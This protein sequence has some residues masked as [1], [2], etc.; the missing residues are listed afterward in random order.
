METMDA[1]YTR[2]SIRN[3]KNELVPKE[4]IAQLLEAAT[5]APSGSNS[6]PWRFVVIQDR[7]ALKNYSSRAKELWLQR[8]QGRPDPQDYKKLLAN[9]DFH[10]FYNAGTLVIIYGDS[11]MPTASLDCS[12]AAQNLMLAAHAQGLGTCWIGFSTAFFNS[13]DF[14][15]ELGIS[16][17]YEAVAPVIVGYPEGVHGNFSRNAPQILAWK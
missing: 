4:M 10:L 6:Q 11:A 9:P 12:L 3:Y 16:E 14:K 13:K 5:M 17:T 2:R 8:M 15:R 7:A 1:I